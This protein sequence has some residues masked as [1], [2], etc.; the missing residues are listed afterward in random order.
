LRAEFRAGPLTL[1]VGEDW[2]LVFKNQ[3]HS[4]G[5]IR[6]VDL[7]PQVP[8]IAESLG[9]SPKEVLGLLLEYEGWAKP[10]VRPLYFEVD[11]A[12]ITFNA[13]EGVRV[14]ASRLYHRERDSLLVGELTYAYAEI[15]KAPSSPSADPK[16]YEAVEPLLI[17][18]HL[19]GGTCLE[20]MARPH[21]MAGRLMVDGQPIKVEL[22]AQYTGTLDTLMSLE[23]VERF[24]DGAEPP[25]WAEAYKQVR[26][27]LEGFVSF[28]WDPRLYDVVSCWVLG[29]YFSEL[30]S[31]Y[32]F[33]YIYGSQGSGKSRLMLTAVYLSRHGFVATDP[34]DASLY[35]AAEAF[36]PT[37]GIDESLLGRE[38]W[39]LIRTAFKRG[40]R[41]P[42]V[43]KTRREEFTLALY[44]TYMPVAFAST[45]RPTELGGCEADEARSLFIFMQQAQDPA[46]R[47]PEPQDFSEL[48]D[49]LYHL[50]LLRAHEVLEALELVRGSGLPLQGHEWEVWLPVLTV[51]RLAGDEV[52][53]NVLGYAGELIAIKNLFQYQEERL[54]IAA[55]ERLL[56]ASPKLPG[57]EP[58]AEFRPRDLLEHVMAELEERGSI[59]RPG[60]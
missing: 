47:D 15:V 50:R 9:A 43:E 56:E 46:G 24:L 45:E 20:R 57:A 58:M 32:P 23:A 29:T 33:L 13:D 25:S 18:T 5:P 17:W 7:L 34:S 8:A 19:K 42:R 35:R 41:V 53:R 26:G 12:Q 40:L 6:D 21:R 37:L 49:R 27:S 48:R 11:E 31:A 52:Y 14:P 59:R 28:P 2:S 22:K 38:A 3:G 44:E 16:C 4:Y 51:A 55:M 30:F 36:R 10:R 60:S 1:E 39:K 54:L